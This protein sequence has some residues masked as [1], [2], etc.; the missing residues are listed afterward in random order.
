MS[1]STPGTCPGIGGLPCYR[2]WRKYKLNRLR[3][4]T[5]FACPCSGLTAPIPTSG[6]M[7]VEL[8]QA[9]YIKATVLKFYHQDR[10]RK[11]STLLSIGAVLTQLQPDNPER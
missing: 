7:P 4:T 11:P 10:K 2:A 8:S 3:K 9:R 6:V 1:S 5:I